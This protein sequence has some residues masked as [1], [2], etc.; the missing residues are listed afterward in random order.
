MENKDINEY[1]LETSLVSDVKF[2]PGSLPDDGW[3]EAFDEFVMQ[4]NKDMEQ[5]ILDNLV[6]GSNN[7]HIVTFPN[8]EPKLTFKHPGEMKIVGNCFHNWAYQGLTECY[9]YC[10][11]CDKKDIDNT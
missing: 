11:K 10:T 1:Q 2:D 4:M 7:R 8:A 6:F 5:Q 9:N 3:R